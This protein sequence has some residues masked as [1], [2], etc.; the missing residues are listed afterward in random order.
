MFRAAVTTDK[1]RKVIEKQVEGFSKLPFEIPGGLIFFELSKPYKL[2]YASRYFLELLGF[3]SLEQLISEN[4]EQLSDLFIDTEDYTQFVAPLLSATDT[5]LLWVPQA[6]TLKTKDGEPKSFTFFRAPYKVR[7][8]YNCGKG[9]LV[10]RKNTLAMSN[11]NYDTLTGLLSMMGFLEE[12]HDRLSELS[13]DECSQY[14]LCYFDLQDFKVF[15]RDYGFEAGSKLLTFI[16]TVVRK[17]FK[18]YSVARFGDD[19]FTV[20]GKNERLRELIVKVSDLVY[21]YQPDLKVAIKAGVYVLESK[22]VQPSEAC[23]NAKAACN[24]IKNKFDCVY[25][26]YDDKLKQELKKKRFFVENLE[27]AIQKGFIQVFYQ[28]VIRIV[29]GKICS[30]EALSR[31][32]DPKKGA[33]SP[34]EFIPVLEQY[35]LIYKL[36]LYVLKCI[37]K[38]YRS[39]VK[40][41]LPVV[42]VSLNLSRIDFEMCDIVSEVDKLVTEYGVPRYYVHIEVTETAINQNEKLLAE[43]IAGFRKLGYALWMDDFGSG[44]SSLNVLKDYDFNVIKFDMQFLRDLNNGKRCERTKEILRSVV[45]MVKR[46]NIQTLTEGVE[47]E[48]HLEFLRSIGCE[49]AQGYLFSKPLPAEEFTRLKFEYEEQEEAQYYDN[50]CRVNLVNQVSL[51]NQV[52]SVADAKALCVLEIGQDKQFRVLLENDAFKEF[53]KTIGHEN[54]RALTDFLNHGKGQHHERLMQLFDNCTAEQQNGSLNYIFNGEFCNTKV[55][56][57]A[58]NK[59]NHHVMLLLRCMNISR[60]S[61]KPK[62]DAVERSLL[63]ILR[64]FDLVGVSDL[65]K[66]QY[67]TIYANSP[68]ESVNASQMSCQKAFSSYRDEFIAKC[69]HERFDRFMDMSTLK[70]RTQDKNRFFSSAVFKTRL[71][72]GGFRLKLYILVPHDV[73]GQRFVLHCRFDPELL[74]SHVKLLQNSELMVDAPYIHHADLFNSLLD[75]TKTA[76]YWKDLNSH[77]KGANQAFSDFYGFESGSDFLGKSSRELGFNVDLKHASE[78]E[79]RVISEGAIV[80]EDTQL[81][82]KGVVKPV[83]LHE[84]PLFHEGNLAGVIGYFTDMSNELAEGAFTDTARRTDAQTGLS[85]LGGLQEALIRYEYAYANERRDFMM[86]KFICLNREE[87]RQHNNEQQL[88]HLEQELF[89]ALVDSLGNN[90]VVARTSAFAGVLL[91]QVDDKEDTDSFKKSVKS[92]VAA[93]QDQQGAYDVIRLRIEVY[94]YKDHEGSRKIRR[95]FENE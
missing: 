91:K 49:K 65:S 95:L 17:V 82:V 45:S 79:Q 19:H 15:N 84:G 58:E 20:F 88:Q 75:L 80:E 54:V 85:D 38:Y 8:D 64:V 24:S 92:A 13:D 36:D 26:E 6:V 27:E 63:A 40:K 50:L 71:P 30:I 89:N 46:L 57:I 66:E 23:D 94:N 3:K 47:T 67:E 72:G 31:W 4:G 69:D 70:R 1:I 39:R 42:P 52:G 53:L 74:G 87:L 73:E 34:F 11:P 37:C 5:K 32:V 14:A 12:L 28:P 41:G 51:D 18:G 81:L 9:F 56:F 29:S 16:G 7:K 55:R 61:D 21:E 48:E 43:A 68:H 93:V 44:Y 62:G 78:L 86:M 76:V 25:A 35:R 60:Y 22:R 33:I 83:H 59:L 90:G 10:E 77:L 2:L